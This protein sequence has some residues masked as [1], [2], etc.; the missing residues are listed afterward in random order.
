MSDIRTNLPTSDT[1]ENDF[2]VL[3]FFQDEFYYRHKHYWSLL[4]KSFTFVLLITTLP[5]TTGVLGF[6][7]LEMPKWILCCFPILGIIISSLSTYVL[8]GE[9]RRMNAV[10]NAK[11][12]INKYLMDKKYQYEFF[13]L[14]TKKSSDQKNHSKWLA[15]KMVYIILLV[16]IL[17]AVGIWIL[18]AYMPS[19]PV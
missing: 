19:T 16:E 1:F 5:I 9:A 7:V 14:D 8:C 15:Y 3:N 13:D 12:R 4:I 6:S 2:K 11:Y 10:N 18:I 17:I